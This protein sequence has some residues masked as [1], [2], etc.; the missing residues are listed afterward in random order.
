MVI[1]KLDV[2]LFKITLQ[3]PKFSLIF[4]RRDLQKER[5]GRRRKHEAEDTEPDNMNDVNR[6]LQYHNN[7]NAQAL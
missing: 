7:L 4:S 3:L 6:L 5:P 2:N 1:G